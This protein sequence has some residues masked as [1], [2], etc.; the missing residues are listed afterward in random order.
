MMHLAVRLVERRRIEPEMKF[1][2][3]LNDH[4]AISS[5]RSTSGGCQHAQPPAGARV[6]NGDG[7]EL[8]VRNDRIG[9]N[10]E[11]SSKMRHIGNH[12]HHVKRSLAT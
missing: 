5:M 12:G 6:E 11:R 9:S 1:R 2:G 3:A 7:V 4:L 8:T 10:D